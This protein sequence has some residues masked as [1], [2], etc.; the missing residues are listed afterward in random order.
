MI[1]IMSAYYFIIQVS[2]I[3]NLDTNVG[4]AP[5]PGRALKGGLSLEEQL[6]F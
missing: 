5:S 6:I 3:A 2:H 1:F 4:G